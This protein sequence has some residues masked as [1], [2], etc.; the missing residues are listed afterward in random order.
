MDKVF[1][2][3]LNMSLTGAFVIAAICLARLPLKKAPK[4]IS[5]CLWAVA[6]FRLLF[7]FSVKSVFSLLPFNAAPI[8]TDIGMQNIPRIDSGIPVLN[9]AV[10]GVLPAAT[11][12]ASANPLQIW[13]ATGAYAWLLGT[14]VMFIYGVASF[15][16]LKRKMRNAACIGDNIYEADNIQSPFVLGVF[17]PKIYLPP[18]LSED[19][20]EY[21]VLHE[22]T[23]IRRYDHIVKFAAYFILCL[24]WFNPFAW[25]GFILCGADMEMSCDE[26]VLREMGVKTKKAYSLSLLSLAVDRRVIGGSPLAFGEGGI[27]ERV[28]NVLRFKKPSRVTIIAAAVLVAVL[29]LGFAMNRADDTGLFGKLRPMTMDT[30]LDEP[31]FSGTITQIFDGHITVS[32]NNGEKILASADLIDVSLDVKLRDSVQEWAVGD[33]VR[34]FYDGAVMESYPAQLRTVYAIVLLE[35]TEPPRAFLLENATERQKFE[36]LTSVTLYADGKA[37][38]TT[39]VISSYILPDCVYA[40]IDT[41]LLIYADIETTFDEDFYGVKNGD[42]IARFKCP[43]DDTIVFV[44]SAVPLFADEG[45]RYVLS[46]PSGARESNGVAR[47]MTLA[48]VRDIAR[49]YGTGLT[50]GDLRGFIGADIGSGRYIMQYEVDG[51]YRLTVNAGGFDDPNPIVDFGKVIDGELDENA[52]D[53]RYYDVDKYIENGTRELVRPLPGT[54]ETAPSGSLLSSAWTPLSD[55]PADFSAQQAVDGGSIYVDIHGKIYNEGVADRFYS[56]VISGGAAFMRTA[57]Y[58]IEGDTIFT[59]YQ[60]DGKTFTVTRDTTRDKFGPQEITAFTYK[61]LV[62]YGHGTPIGYYL[63][64]TENIYTETGAFIEKLCYIPPPSG[65]NLSQTLPEQDEDAALFIIAEIIEHNLDILTSSPSLSS[66]SNDYIDA[67]RAE[68]EEIVALGN[69]AL[70]Y[71]YSLFDKGGQTGLRGHIMAS[72]CRDI[73]G[74][75]FEYG[76]DTDM[77]GQKWYD[78]YMRSDAAYTPNPDIPENN[79]GFTEYPSIST[80]TS[81]EIRTYALYEW[82]CY[83]INIGKY[84][85]PAELNAMADIATEELIINNFTTMMKMCEYNGIIF[86]VGLGVPGANEYIWPSEPG[87]DYTQQP[88]TVNADIKLTYG[89]APDVSMSVQNVTRT[90]LAFTLLNTSDKEYTYSEDYILYIRRNGAWERLDEEAPFNSI[91]YSLPPNSKTEAADI[92]WGWLYGKLEN[93]EYKIEKGI[94]YRRAPG[95]YDSYVAECEFT[96]YF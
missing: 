22:K 72:A 38:L 79:F 74:L 17:T 42:V 83:K 52:I 59:D 65:G 10:S 78:S 37:I 24:H 50:L 47:I 70:K 44:S 45:A 68:Y 57:Q 8:P 30:V 16:I 61:Y 12:A 66:N 2:T 14:A 95:D 80:L 5:Y 82:E 13:T 29:S 73:L 67:H 49:E 56:D 15:I 94:I 60:Y 34:V 89:K 53:I 64:N 39:P 32:A 23:H 9:N 92:D 11:P 4:A 40:Y 90:G 31:N 43:D 1:L 21:I 20:R 36:R 88:E 71:M 19:E 25:I 48:D 77:V 7:P 58:T 6:G 51:G 75:K 87:P 18:G 91:G 26:R 3:V 33:V 62:P 54:R 46:V 69:D 41:E 84:M 96:I 86:P 93:G 27:K 81:D 76:H 28:K 85:S 55:L 63:S 35:R